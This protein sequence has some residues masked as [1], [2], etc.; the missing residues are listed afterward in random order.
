MLRKI[1][2]FIWK[3]SGTAEIIDNVKATRYGIK[4]AQ[5]IQD[6]PWIKHKGF[7]FG[8]F[9]WAMDA[10]SMHNL[11]RIL[12]DVKPKNILEF[13]LGQS[14][15]MIHQYA[16][17]YKANALTVE[18]DK[19]WISYFKNHASQINLN[20]HHVD[21]EGITIN[22]TKTVSS[23]NITQIYEDW[24]MSNNNGGEGSIVILDGICNSAM[25]SCW[26][27]K[28][29]P[30]Y[31]R[32]QLLEFFPSQDDSFCVFM[33]DSESSGNQNTL[34]LF[35]KNLTQNKIE[36]LRKEY[37]WSLRLKQQHTIVCSKSWKYLTSI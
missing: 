7:S 14:S 27:T 2:N 11:F 33:H 10:L 1:K 20:I 6:C 35:C 21:L 26:N 13:G 36:Y 3:H 25:E 19:D 30:Y 29:K 31:S 37:N 23:K 24:K 15:K 17:Y 4:F 22:D 28:E 5:A 8:E 12:E 32:P 34:N 18:H 9:G 16:E